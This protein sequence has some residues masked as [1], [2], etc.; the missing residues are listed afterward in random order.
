MIA[1]QHI[2][3]FVSSSLQYFLNCELENGPV[4]IVILPMNSMVILHTSANVYQAR[5]V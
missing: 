3:V 1:Y 5:Y 2:S 4:E